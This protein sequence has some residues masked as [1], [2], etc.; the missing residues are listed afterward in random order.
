MML[1]VDA[2]SLTITGCD[3][4]RNKAYY[5]GAIHLLASN[6]L[7]AFVKDCQ[8]NNNVATELGGAALLRYVGVLQWEGTNA[9]EN[10]ARQGGNTI[11]D[12]QLFPQIANKVLFS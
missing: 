2:M 10:R 3:F 11:H 5:G 6:S 9:T 8:F 7:S 12:R 4:E 1:N